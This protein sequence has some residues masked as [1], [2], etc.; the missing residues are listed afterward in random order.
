MWEKQQ[1]MAKNNKNIKIQKPSL[2]N[3]NSLC[4]FDYCQLV[5]F[6]FI[7]VVYKGNTE[8]ILTKHC[9]LCNRKYVHINYFKD[10]KKIGIGEDDYYNLNLEDGYIRDKF[11]IVSKPGTAKTVYKKQTI[12]VPEL[13][14][15]NKKMS[16]GVTYQPAHVIQLYKYA[17]DN[18]TKI[19]TV[20]EKRIRSRVTKRIKKVKSCDICGTI[21]E[22]GSIVYKSKK[23]RDCYIPIKLCKQ[24]KI[25]Y[26]AFNNYE[27]FSDA[28]ECEN[29]DELQRLKEERAKKVSLSSTNTAKKANIKNA[30]PTVKIKTTALP[31]LNYE[32]EHNAK[33]QNKTKG[34]KTTKVI[35]QTVQVKDFV[36]RRSVFK[37]MHKDHSL[38]NVDAV[39]SLVTNKGETINTTVS[40]GYCPECNAYFIMEST[41]Q[42]LKNRG[43]P[44]CRVSDEKAYLQGISYVNGMKLANESLLMQYGYN[45]SQQEG[46]TETRRHKILAVLIDNK[47]MTKSEIISYLDFFISQRQGRSMYEVAIH[48]WSTDRD[49]V[50]EYNSGS[51]TRV[52]I[53]GILR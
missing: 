12:K 45:V 1:N 17:A 14:K 28:L 18:K 38:Q 5:S 44:L 50:E 27:V 20:S 53:S 7:G 4:P 39:I 8:K 21:V 11:I 6:Q 31:K 47:I 24:C 23:G 34:Q 35:K 32:Y 10:L 48:K 2:E 22:N 43:T 9:P 19:G 49:F 13:N 36:V 3:R 30:Q 33:T 29:A 52:G 37:C 51:Y 40:A 16:H 41:Y 26:I 25:V 42:M 15:G 46:L